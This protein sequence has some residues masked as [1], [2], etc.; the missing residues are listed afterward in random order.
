LST[1]TL[2][3][4][5]D[6]R[7]PVSERRSE[8]IIV[9]RARLVPEPKGVSIHGKI[10]GFP[11]SPGMPESHAYLARRGQGHRSRAAIPTRDWFH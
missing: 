7:N 6:D 10:R 3:R 11:S 4:K 2:I 8:A 1:E 9:Y 5:P